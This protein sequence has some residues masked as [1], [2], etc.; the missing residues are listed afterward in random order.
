MQE[1][2][3]RGS[4]YPLRS[5]SVAADAFH[6]HR[7][8]QPQTPADVGYQPATSRTLTCYSGME[9][10]APKSRQTST[11]TTGNDPVEGVDPGGTR[12]TKPGQADKS[13]PKADAP[14]TSQETSSGDRNTWRES[15]G[16]RPGSE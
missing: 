3:D 12:S 4:W 1:I 14:A 7:R 15:R 16:P 8:R 6:D 2:Q 5:P 10:Q 11:H 9:Q 13:Q